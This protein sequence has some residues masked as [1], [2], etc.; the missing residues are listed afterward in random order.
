MMNDDKHRTKI[1][2][3]WQK[4]A[5]IQIGKGG[6]SDTLVKE[7]VRLLKKHHYIKVRML[8]SVL[9][10]TTKEYLL[11]SL[12]ERTGATFAGLRGNTGVIYKIRAGQ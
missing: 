10:T 1:S 8:R 3:A 7:T 6:V 4:P 11:N 12:C 5:M 2:V 9:D